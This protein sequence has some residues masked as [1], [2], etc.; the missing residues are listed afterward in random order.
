MGYAPLGATM[1]ILL[2]TYSECGSYHDMSEDYVLES[3]E[4]DPFQHAILS[5]G[6]GGSIYTDVGA[7]LLCWTA[8]SVILDFQEY[9]HGMEAESMGLHIITKADLIAKMM[10][11]TPFSLDATLIV[12]Y[13]LENSLY[14]HMYGDGVVITIDNDDHLNY[15][16]V[17]Y[18]PKN[19]PYYL[20][21]LLNKKARLS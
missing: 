11:I 14:A 12:T 4:N 1:K 6:C 20:S 10:R 18:K 15:E 5:D 21:Y 17:D 3:D 19:A 13:L 9:L 7:R 2:D 16:V 8:K